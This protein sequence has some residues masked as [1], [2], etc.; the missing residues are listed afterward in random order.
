MQIT[1]NVF[2][3]T[4]INN[5][6]EDGSLLINKN[7][8][9]E[10]GLWP[11][12]ARTYFIDTILTNFPFP[13]ITIR[14]TIDIKTRK[15]I[16]EIID[17]QQR[18][19]T[20]N[21]FINNKFKLTSVSKRFNNLKFSDLDEDLQNQ[22]LRYEVSV[23]TI[24]A[25]SEE[26]ILEIFRRINSYT[27]PLNEA[28]KRHATYQGE[29]K[30]FVK[31]LIEQYTKYFETFNILSTKNISRMYD[32]DLISEI[33]QLFI[34]GIQSRSAKKLEELYKN[35]DKNFE[36]KED[37]KRKIDEVFNYMKVELN[38]VLSSNLVPSYIF[39]SLTAALILNKWGLNNTEGTSLIEFSSIDV[40][41]L[42]PE[43]SNQN[44][45]VLLGA[46]DT[47]NTD[48]EYSEFV[49]ASIKTTDSINNRITRT[50]WFVKALRNL[51]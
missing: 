45:L 22:F 9:R 6:L 48:G 12:N 23:D 46:F 44:L 19:T 30:W 50:Y 31:D 26:E 25:A 15:S 27:L 24:I 41:T 4:D 39:Y 10:R 38:Q 18:I 14:Q 37:I 33:I 7:Y 1:R 42:E 5:W 35:N 49:K 40:F 11:V 16:R 34:S 20:V 47:K 29:F 32:A 43:T 21:D 13:K 36:N 51:M 8:Q 3:I 17:G 28:E 2:T